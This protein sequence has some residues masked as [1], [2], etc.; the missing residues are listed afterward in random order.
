MVRFAALLLPVPLLIGTLLAL[1]LI[2]LAMT[3]GS[4]ATA[5]AEPAGLE[6]SV[7]IT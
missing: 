6:V 7:R 5:D 3:Y 4:I 2:M 1:G